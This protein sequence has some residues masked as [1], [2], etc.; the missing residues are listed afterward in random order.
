MHSNLLEP[1]TTYWSQSQLV[2]ASHNILEPVTDCWSRPKQI[3]ATQGLVGAT[4]NL[5][6][7]SQTDWSH[8][9]FSGL[10]VFG[11][12]FSMGLLRD[13]AVGAGDVHG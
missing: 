12:Y 8:S 11:E 4:H 1:V 9:R 2:G 10:N 7:P 6:E 13:G 3:G 5:L